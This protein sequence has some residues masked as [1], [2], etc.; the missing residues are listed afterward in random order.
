M[1]LL[2]IFSIFILLHVAAWG[3]T[4]VYLSNNTTKILLVVDTSYAMKP[5]FDDM[6]KW[7]VDLES[8][9]HYKQI[10]IGTDKALL[11]DLT[12]LKSKDVIFRTAFGRMNVDNLKR[13]TSTK[14]KKKILLSDG[15]IKPDGWQIVT[16]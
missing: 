15:S 5:K 3:A 16:F 10:I 1:K 8:S 9:S 12:T 6:R 14:A 7:I 13:Y 11:G 2:K 4:H